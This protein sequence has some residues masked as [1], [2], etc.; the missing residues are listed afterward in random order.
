M[1]KAITKFRISGGGEREVTIT[2]P[3]R[4]VALK[5]GLEDLML[6]LVWENHMSF[7]EIIETVNKLKA[8]IEAAGLKPRKENEK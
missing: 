2:N 3:N 8:R 4:G 1:S 7:D 6:T 5:D